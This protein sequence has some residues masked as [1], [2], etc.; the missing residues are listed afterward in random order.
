MY[1]RA[2]GRERR[3]LNTEMKGRR[4]KPSREPRIDRKTRADG[5]VVPEMRTEKEVEEAEGVEARE[6]E[7]ELETVWCSRRGMV[8]GNEPWPKEHGGE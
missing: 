7:E 8:A 4:L 2:T 1:E 6:T 5:R 3:D